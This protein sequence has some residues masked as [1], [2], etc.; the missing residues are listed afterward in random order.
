MTRH[1]TNLDKISQMDCMIFQIVHSI[2]LLC[3]LVPSQCGSLVLGGRHKDVTVIVTEKNLMAPAFH[4]T[5]L[6]ILRLAI[7][8]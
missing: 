7:S 3:T 6:C 5:L 8:K 1:K 2:V 4:Q